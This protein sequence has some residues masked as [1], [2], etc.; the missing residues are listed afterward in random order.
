[1]APAGRWF[2]YLTG[3]LD[4]MVHVLAWDPAGDTGSLV[5]TLPAL[6]AAPPDRAGAD[7]ARDHRDGGEHEDGSAAL[8]RAA[9]VAPSPSHLVLDGRELVVGVRGAEV[10]S[11]FAVGDDGLLTHRVDQPLPARTPRDLAVVGAWTVVAEQVPG[12]VTV[13]DRDGRVASSRAIP[14]AACVAPAS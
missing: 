5:Q 2:A 4:A 7:P 11:R 10:L 8:L 12:A 13:V 3:E 14:S 9:D 1:M 6:G